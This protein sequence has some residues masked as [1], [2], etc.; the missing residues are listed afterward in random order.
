M[1]ELQY[2]ASYHGY[3]AKCTFPYLFN[4]QE[5][6]D[7][8]RNGRAVHWGVI[9]KC[10]IICYVCTHSKCYRLKLKYTEIVNIL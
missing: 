8:K 9:I 6:F 4:M 5:I 10:A 1:N 2:S 3:F 7:T